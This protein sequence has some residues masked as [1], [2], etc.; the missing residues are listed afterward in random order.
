MFAETQPKSLS[1][2]IIKMQQ[3]IGTF[4]VGRIKAKD[5]YE[6]SDFDIRRIVQDRDFE[7]YLGIQRPISTNRLKE[8]RQYVTAID[9]T[10]PTSIIISVS[11]DCV[12]LRNLENEPMKEEDTF[13]NL[14]LSN[15]LEP[16][17][18]NDKIPYKYIAKVLDGQHRIAGLKDYHGDDFEL[19]VTIF[20][21]ADIADQANIFS[22]V[23]LAQTKVNKSLVYDLF[24]L[25][26]SR[27]PERTCHEIVVAL[28]RTEGSPFFK[29]IKRLG[30]ATDGRSGE[31]LAQATVVSMILHYI[32]NNPASDRDTLKR[33]KKL[34]KISEEQSHRFIFRNMFIDEEDFK[35]TDIIWNYFEAINQ[36]WPSAW[37]SSGT[38]YILN[39]T[40]GYRGFMRFL[41][42]AYLYYTAPGEVVTTQQFLRLFNKVDVDDDYFTV[43]NFK[44]GTSGETDIYKMLL[45]RTNLEGQETLL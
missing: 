8:L 40:N 29:R 7:T 45:K 21:G 12:D 24:A 41:K 28:D 26:N 2:P 18:D 19:N 31:T 37:T 44:P 36:R 32:T 23:N 20:I 33:G 10:F 43:D 11:E 30:V 16:A 38:G 6:I 9:A 27:S 39:R 42:H 35:I 22:T 5:L 17:D 25:S 13:G 14:I 3:P 34:S 1:V 4:Y 15:Y